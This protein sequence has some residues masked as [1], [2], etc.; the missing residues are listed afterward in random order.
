MATSSTQLIIGSDAPCNEKA[1]LSFDALCYC[2][3]R[4]VGKNPFYM[5]VDTDWTIID[6]NDETSDSQGCFPIGS[7]CAHKFAPGVLFQYED[8]SF[9]VTNQ[10]QNQGA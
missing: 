7:T 8:N 1:T 4:K 3:G 10:I 6:R 9:A 2:C 5:H